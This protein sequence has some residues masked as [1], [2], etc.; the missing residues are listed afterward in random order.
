MYRPYRIIGSS[1]RHGIAQRLQQVLLDW[2]ANWLTGFDG[3]SITLDVQPAIP[4]DHKATLDAGCAVAGGST[5][6]L[7]G[8]IRQWL[9]HSTEAPAADSISATLL[10]QACAELHGQFLHALRSMAEPVADVTWWT[11]YRGLHSGVIRAAMYWQ[12]QLIMEFWLSPRMTRHSPVGIPP[13]RLHLFGKLPLNCEIV[14]KTTEVS[15]ND[16]L[17]LR[18]GDV[19]R[20]EQGIGEAVTLRTRGGHSVCRG[21][22]GRNGD[23]KAFVATEPSAG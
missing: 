8:Q 15:V 14:L 16:L 12:G 7:F 23:H 19:V 1:Q 6:V 20:V 9:L 21:Y 17:N 22:L 10:Q 3:G 4:A 18:P 2:A 13:I 5:D 11:S